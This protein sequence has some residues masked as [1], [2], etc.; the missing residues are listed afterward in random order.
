LE[1]REV[2]LSDR[3]TE[4]SALKGIGVKA[5]GA[6]VVAKTPEHLSAQ[7]AAFPQSPFPGVAQ[8]CPCGQQS[9]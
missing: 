3:S 1:E 8:S 6:S 5:D 7:D 4:F 2:G 9:D